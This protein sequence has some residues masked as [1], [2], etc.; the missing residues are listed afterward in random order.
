MSARFGDTLKNSSSSLH[1]ERGEQ[2][3]ECESVCCAALVLGFLMA[4]PCKQGLVVLFPK[5]IQC[6]DCLASPHLQTVCA[7]VR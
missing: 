1:L 7:G 3:P 2:V 6:R 5:Y 4:Q